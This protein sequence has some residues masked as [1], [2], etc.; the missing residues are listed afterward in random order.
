MSKFR[1]DYFIYYRINIYNINNNW[2]VG[3]IIDKKQIIVFNG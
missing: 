1:K 2:M 3:Y